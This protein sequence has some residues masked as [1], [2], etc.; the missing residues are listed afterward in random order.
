MIAVITL[1]VSDESQLSFLKC[2]F[3]FFVPGCGEAA[4]SGSNYEKLQLKLPDN[5][6]ENHA[7]IDNRVM[8]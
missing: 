1:E 5:A 7:E 4:N 2:F 3:C 6:E 8:G